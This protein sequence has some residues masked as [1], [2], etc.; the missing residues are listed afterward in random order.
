VA[1]VGWVKARWGVISQA[2]PTESIV[3]IVTTDGRLEVVV[4][5]TLL[6][7]GMPICQLVLGRTGGAS[8]KP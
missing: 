3:E 8:E 6:L 1:L 2:A 4:P 5:S 7:E